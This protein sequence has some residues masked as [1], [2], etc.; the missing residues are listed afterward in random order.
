MNTPVRADPKT[1]I[2]RWTRAMTDHDLDSAMSCFHPDYR[3]EAPARRGELTRGRE[4]VRE[5]FATLFNEIPDLKA[6]LLRCVADGDIVWMEWRLHGTRRDGPPFEF[7]GVNLFGVYNGQ[8]VWGRIYSELVRDAGD[9]DAQIERMTK[10]TRMNTGWTSLGPSKVRFHARRP[11]TKGAYSLV[12]WV[13]APPPAAGPPPH[14]HRDADEACYVLEGELD[15]TVEASEVRAQ[16]GTFVLIARG[17]PHSLANPGPAPVR[18]LIILSP[19]GFEGFWE[20]MSELLKTT[21]R[22]EPATVLALQEKYHF[23]AGGQV[24]RFE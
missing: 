5:N 17:A 8:I 16:P 19:P 13:M 18:F 11:E 2:E 3:D 9:I 21:G 20:E 24:R 15:V 10:A 4:K 1:L 22:P 14:V 12:E 23:D 7:V 6:D